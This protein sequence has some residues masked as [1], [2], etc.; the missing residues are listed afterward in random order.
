MST[1]TRTLSVKKAIELRGAGVGNTII[2]DNASSGYLILWDLRGTTNQKA[3][4]TGIEIQDGGFT[5]QL[6]R[7]RVLSSNTNGSTFR[8]DHSKWNNA[9]GVALNPDTVFG[10]CDHVDFFAPNYVDFIRPMATEWDGHGYGDGSWN[11]PPNF[12]SSEFFF[13]EDCTFH[14]PAGVYGPVTDAFNGARFV[15]RHCTV[16]DGSI[17]SHGTE[18]S[19]RLRGT[20]AI[21]AYN[22]TFVGTNLNKFLGLGRFGSAV[23]HGN[24]A[25]G[26]VGD[27]A[28]FA[29]SNYRAIETFAVFGGADGTNVWDKNDTTGG[30]GHNGIYF[31][32]TAASASSGQTVT[33]SGSPGWTPNQWATGGYVLR[34]T[35]NV[36]GVTTITFG[37]IT[38][39]TSNTIS[40]SGTIHSAPM[41]FCAGDTLEIRKVIL[42]MDQ[43][44]AGEGSLVGGDTPKP[45]PTWNDEVAQPV[46]CWNNTNEFGHPINYQATLSQN[47]ISGIHFINGVARPGYTPYIYPHPLVSGAA[48]PL[49]PSPAATR[50]SLRRPWGGKKQQKTKE[51][52]RKPEKKTKQNPANEMAESQEKLGN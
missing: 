23:A 39:N 19:G 36:C 43:I 26:Y 37:S 17:Q 51:L 4:L 27:N 15:V 12:G 9:K 30:P 38:G 34:R 14:W 24:H 5:G 1:W 11:K 45:P 8:W 35:S 31:S 16:Y 33:V 40:Y 29:G 21:E 32:G 41:T 28:C 25:S 2:K 10:V 13:I 44:G 3:R 48:L 20:R 42:I 7:I 18:S 52:K 49:L 50:T 47:Q 6:Y 22:N 46:Y